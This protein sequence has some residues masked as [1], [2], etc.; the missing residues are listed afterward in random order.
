MIQPDLNWT[1][2]GLG[3]WGNQAAWVVHFEQ[4]PHAPDVL[5]WFQG[6]RHSFSL[7]L[8]GRV[9]ISEQ[10]YQALHLDTDL[11]KPIRSIDLRREH[12]SINYAPVSFTQHDVQLWLPDSVDTYIQFEGHFLHYYHRF[13]DFK[14]FW[15][16]SSQKIGK[17]K[18]A[19]KLQQQNKDQQQQH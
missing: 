9:W 3:T 17:P 6:P 5:L 18:E 12:F 1:C 8:K 10:T 15:V 19:E 13:S 7:P 14:L 11:L 2:E 16:G 4:K